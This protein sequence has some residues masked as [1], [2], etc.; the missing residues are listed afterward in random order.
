[1]CP[2]QARRP[3]WYGATPYLSLLSVLVI[4]GCT[5]TSPRS[6][7]LASD[8]VFHRT[9]PKRAFTSADQLG[10]FELPDD[11]A[12][13]LG[14]GDVVVIEVWDRQDLSGR[15]II[16][17][18][19]QVTLPVVGPVR[20]A[21]LTREEAARTAAAMLGRYYTA[22]VVTVRV[23]QYVSNR[24]LVLGRVSKP[25]LITFETPPTLL[26]AITMAGALPVG[27][28]G[29]EKAALGRCAIFRGRDRIVWVELRN[30]LTGENPGLNLRLRR[31]DVVYIPDADDQLV[32]VLGEVQK[33][34]ALRL[35]PDMSFMDAFASAGGLTRDAAPD[36]IHLIRPSEGANRE[37]SLDALLKPDSPAT[38]A[39]AEGDIL[40]APKR[41]LAEVGYVL[42]KLSP[43][44]SYL[45]I[46]TAFATR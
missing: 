17:P 9:E 4:A 42:E 23:E 36:R 41:G 24:V 7:P 31:N 32:Y 19:G 27:G 35:T 40:Y 38:L 29:A 25:G 28:V 11:G 37:V 33:P 44:T 43:L 20:L 16:G 5:L 13:H 10:S 34:G 8:E 12:Y 2:V 22:L 39:L 26:E 1:M 15:H 30:L 21:D 6:L 3:Q 14:E 45:L 46:G 18:D